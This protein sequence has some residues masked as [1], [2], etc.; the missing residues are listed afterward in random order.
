MEI[1]EPTEVIINNNKKVNKRIDREHGVAGLLHFTIYVYV[2]KFWYKHV[3]EDHWAVPNPV[4]GG[5]S[6]YSPSAL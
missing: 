4:Y 3:A 1:N 5:P 6:L 2:T